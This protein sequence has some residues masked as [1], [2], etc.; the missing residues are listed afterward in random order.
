VKG[1]VAVLC[2]PESAPGIGLAGIEPVVIE[3]RATI[4]S[5]LER[6]LAP[7]PDRPL[8]LLVEEE[9]HAAIPPLWWRRLARDPALVVVPFPSAHAAAAA[10][11]DAYVREL[12]RQAI[13]YRVR[14]Q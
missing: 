1:R 14:L 5:A 8:V 9:L 7:G 13:G 2:G 3:D 4:G 12:L 11:P 6:L 10:A